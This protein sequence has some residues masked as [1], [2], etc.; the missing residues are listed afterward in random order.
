VLD[1]PRQVSNAATGLRFELVDLSRERIQR[2]VAVH[3]AGELARIAAQR[4]REIAFL[5]EE[6]VWYVLELAR[7]EPL[8][9]HEGYE[10]VLAGDAEVELLHQLATVPAMVAARRRTGGAE[11]WMVL[12]DR[13]PAFSCFVFSGSAPVRAAR[14]GDL[15]LRSN[16]LC[17]ENSYTAP[18]HRRKGLARSAWTQIA[19]RKNKPGLTMITKVEAGN[20][21]S[22]RAVAAAGFRE[23]ATMA[24]TKRGPV[25]R[26]E[27]RPVQG[28]LS[29]TEQ[30]VI[31]ELTET[32]AR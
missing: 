13:D 2:A 11:L 19:A 12:E 20:T 24:L 30:R 16:V 21:P 14:G 1:E 22:R 5:S 25:V 27:I 26:V 31:E 23:G 4:A 7:A 28:P 32:L 29:P 18:K 10:L 6:H 15:R 9:L 3:S 17:L 8:P